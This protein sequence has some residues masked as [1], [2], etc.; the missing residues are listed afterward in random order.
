MELI[1]QYQLMKYDENASGRSA[2]DVLNVMRSWIG[3]SEANGKFRQ[4]IDLY[5][6]HQ[7]LARDMPYSIPMSGVI[8]QFLQQRFRQTVWT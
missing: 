8:P 2:Q 1:E 4:I 5:N 6:S 7:P 3:Y